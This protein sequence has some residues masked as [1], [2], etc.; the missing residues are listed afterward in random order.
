MT[1]EEENGTAVMHRTPEY[2]PSRSWRTWLIGRPLSTADAPHQAISK[3]VG[4]AVF[5]SDAMSSVAYGPQEL[6]AILAMAGAAGLAYSVPLAIGIVVLLAILTISY[7]QTIHAYLNGGG[8]YIV[9]RDNLG[10]VPAQTAGAALLSDYVLTVAVSISSSVAQL[11]SAFPGLDPFRVELGVGLVLFVM[12]VNLRGV[13]ESGSVFAVPTYFF[14]VTM[15]LTVGL[16]LFRYLSGSLG[17]VVDPPA[18]HIMGETQAVTILLLLRAFANGT[19]AVTGV[20]AISDG[21]PAFQQP[22]SRNAGITLVWMAI[23]LGTLLLGITFLAH[24]IGAVPSEQETI[25]SQL[26]RTALEGRGILYLI[27]IAGTTVILV[28]AANTAYADFPRL[29]A[30]LAADGYLPR[31]LA[32]RGSRLVFSRGIIALALTA[33]LLI[34]LFRASVASLIPLYAIGV[35]LSFTLSQSGM[36]RRWWKIGRL[37]PG[38]EIQERASTLRED[39]HWRTK[40]LVNGFGAVVTAFVAVVFAATKFQDGAYIVLILIPVLVMI[41][42]AIHRHY[43][44]VAFSLSLE[45]YGA[46]ATVA[47]HRVILP[48]SGVHRGTLAAVR[49]ARLLS[50]DITAVH[51]SIDPDEAERLSEKWELWGRGSGW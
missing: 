30:F 47:R 9:S 18:L 43:R 39:P 2:K 4:L 38:E 11:V 7:E 21:I 50:D 46:P 34:V 37:K 25:I 44:R 16:G 48:L 15:F 26:A 35:F 19:S 31:Q 33:S 12:L 1:I 6:M 29:A 40:M 24:Q 17:S 13:K 41:F 8:S 20:E 23:I 5:S 14:I 10:A 49:Y 42:S 36:A 22:R 51:V 27:V 28:M 3:T 32:F 45:H